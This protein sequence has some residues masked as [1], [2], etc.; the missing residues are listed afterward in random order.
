MSGT[1]SK[2]KGA[3][4]YFYRNRVNGRASQDLPKHRAPASD[5]P[6]ERY[7]ALHWISFVRRR[8]GHNSSTRPAGRRTL[9]CN[10]PCARWGCEAV[11][12]AG[13]QSGHE[14]AYCVVSISAADPKP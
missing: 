4:G 14:I 10:H 8:T 11:M 9:G 6:N 7:T 1:N 13:S 5:A 12:G 3:R 2:G